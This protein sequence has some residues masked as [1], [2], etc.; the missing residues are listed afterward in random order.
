MSFTILVTSVVLAAGL[1][2]LGWSVFTIVAAHATVNWPRAIG[3][4]EQSWIAERRGSED[5]RYFEPRVRY[6]YFVDGRH[7]V[8]TQV[9]FGP[10]WSFS[11]RRP[12]TTVVQKY[13]IGA[14][15]VVAYN[16]NNPE[17]SV[18][19]AGSIRSGVL[20]VAFFV[21]VVGGAL[22]VILRVA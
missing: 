1:I 17:E 3:T 5:E 18:L 2:G 22:F 9:S 4:V 15:V 19:E 8:G 12:A 6:R 7:M 10:R 13:P 11:W 20:A 21:I 14:G 16:P